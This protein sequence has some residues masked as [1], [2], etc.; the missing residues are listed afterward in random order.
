MSEGEL[1][2][3]LRDPP[4][5]LVDDL[6]YDS[7]GVFMLQCF[8]EGLPD[9]LVRL[10]CMRGTGLADCPL[11]L[12]QMG[13]HYRYRLVV[14]TG[15][16]GHGTSRSDRT[17]EVNAGGR[18]SAWE[19]RFFIP[20]HPADLGSRVPAPW[21]TALDILVFPVVPRTTW[22]APGTTSSLRTLGCAAIA[23]QRVG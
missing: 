15:I 19:A 23:V 8:E 1:F 7:L 11:D 2:R 13:R 3:L 14:L 16:G 22:H 17:Y 10:S 4:G 12:R 6:R 21:W 9:R 18:P 5:E 20:R